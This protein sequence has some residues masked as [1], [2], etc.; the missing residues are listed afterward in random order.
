MTLETFGPV[1]NVQ[2][3]PVE[4]RESSAF[5]I[6]WESPHGLE[7]KG[8]SYQVT[9]CRINKIDTCKSTEKT[10]ERRVEV[11]G[12]NDDDIYQWEVKIFDAENNPGKPIQDTYKTKKR[13]KRQMFIFV[14]SHLFIRPFF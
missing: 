12:L 7:G 2:V 6:S 1:L 3:T 10:T 4:F 9:Y 8:F 14:N 11:S 5:V 13:G